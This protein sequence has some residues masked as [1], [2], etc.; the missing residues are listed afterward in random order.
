MRTK[1]WIQTLAV[2]LS[3][4]LIAGTSQAQRPVVPGSGVELTQVGDDFEDPK[5]GYIYN[6]PKSTEDINEMQNN[7]W[8]SRPMVVGTRASNAANPISSNEC[9]LLQVVYPAVKGP[10]YC[11][12]CSLGYPTTQPP[13]APR[14][15]YCQRTISRGWTNRCFKNA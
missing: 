10:C 12:P 13:D 5:W 3:V 11:N 1:Y 6:N 4:S 14:G 8:A 7:H 9:R 15:L 2:G